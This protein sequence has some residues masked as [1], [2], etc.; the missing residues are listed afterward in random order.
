M[1]LTVYL[2]LDCE[3]GHIDAATNGSKQD[4]GDEDYAQFAKKSL[5]VNLVPSRKLKT[6][7]P[8][9][10][11]GLNF[12]QNHLENEK[13]YKG[14]IGKRDNDWKRQ[15]KGSRKN[16]GK[17]KTVVFLDECGIFI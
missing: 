15:K 10:G 11:M 14:R 5:S 12:I 9:S 7:L 6:E 2:G 8:P 13:S 4:I 17:R 3:H 1:G 16:K